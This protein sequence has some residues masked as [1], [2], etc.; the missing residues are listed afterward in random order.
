MQNDNHRSTKR[1]IVVVLLAYAVAMG[2]VEAAVVIY[3]RE[4]YYP[5]GFFVKTAADLKIIPWDILRVEIWREVATIIMLVAASSLAFNRL[6][7]KVWAFILAFSIWDLFYYLFL[8][9]F[10]RWPPSLGTTDVY[11]LIPWPWIGPVWIP[12]LLFGVL[13]IISLRQIL[14][15]YESR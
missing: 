14:K 6:K 8:Y 15:S 4:L 3:L 2:L 13:G 1:K 11:F 5:A 10:L 12:L 7:E 9:I